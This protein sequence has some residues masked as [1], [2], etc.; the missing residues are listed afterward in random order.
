MENLYL[1][2]FDCLHKKRN[3]EK[4]KHNR[5][6]SFFLHWAGHGMYVAAAAASK[7]YKF[8]MYFSVS[9]FFRSF[10]RLED[11]PGGRGRDHKRFSKSM[12]LVGHDLFCLVG[13]M[14][15]MKQSNENG[16]YLREFY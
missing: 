2:I 1:F 10:A 4:R 6:V 12:I 11:E 9:L 14:N 8:V 5:T 16:L 3:G 7:V 15:I 13:L